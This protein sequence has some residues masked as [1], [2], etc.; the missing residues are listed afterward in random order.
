MAV[1]VRYKMVGFLTVGSMINYADRV[2]ISVAAP[3]MMASLGWDKAQFGLLFSAFLAGYMLLQFPGGAIADRWNAVK[4]LAVACLGFSAFTA[5][6]PLG[7]FSFGLMLA[8]RFSVGLF[9]GVSFP[10]CAALNSRWIPRHEYGRAQTL[11]VAGAFLGQALSYPMTAWLVLTFSWPIAFYVNA[12]LGVAWLAAWLLF[13]TNSPSEHSRISA[14]ELRTIAN[15][16]AKPDA[17]PVSPWSV[18]REPQV[19]LLSLSYVCLMFGL[20]MIVFWLP[21]YLVEVRGLSMKQMGWIGII[22]TLASFAG[23]VSGGILSD[24]LL[25]HGRSLRFSRARG[26]ALCLA[27]GV[28][29]LVAAPLVPTVVGSVACFTIYLFLMNASVGGHWGVPL[30]MDPTRAGAISGVMS[31]SGSLGGVL[32]PMTAGFILG[33][34][35]SWAAPFLVAATVAAISF[36]IYFFL[37]VPAALPGRKIGSSAVV[38]G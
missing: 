24:S 13:A 37:V 23:L 36:L 26:P 30:E 16:V 14:E 27:L 21:T 17:A 32:G 31:G 35:D 25:R 22:P 18:I 28:P 12:A 9:E 19:L 10:A 1:P 15:N 6:T 20:W 5:L 7:Q 33:A 29:F 4:L 2:N 34:L 3:A 8:I 11:S 38:P